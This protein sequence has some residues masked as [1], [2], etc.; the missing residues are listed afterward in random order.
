M[1]KIGSKGKSTKT[2]NEEKQFH[3]PMPA[4]PL[5]Q[6]ELDISTPPD[7]STHTYVEQPG[8][9]SYQVDRPGSSTRSVAFNTQNEC[10]EFCM[11]KTCNLFGQTSMIQMAVL[12]PVKKVKTQGTTKVLQPVRKSERIAAA[13]SRM[14]TLKRWTVSKSGDVY[15]R[16]YGHPHYKDV[17][18]WHLTPTVPIARNK[19]CRGLTIAKG[20]GQTYFKLGKRR[21]TRAKQKIDASVQKEEARVRTQ[22]KEEQRVQDKARKATRTRNRIKEVWEEMIYL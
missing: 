1:T 16:V 3:T 21:S 17:V 9:G 4:D 12:T 14:P 13:T 5:T 7:P 19:L 22:E 10:R 2:V 18:K 15:G 8:Q 6:E 20:N 11:D